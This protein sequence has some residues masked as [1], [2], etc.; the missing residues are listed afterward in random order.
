M[1]KKGMLPVDELF[2]VSKMVL[3]LIVVI[4]ILVI[5]GRYLFKLV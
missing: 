3:V 5:I 4:A 2:R 1:Q